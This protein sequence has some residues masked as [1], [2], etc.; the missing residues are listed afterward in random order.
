[1]T[2][3][4][5]WHT[6]S[7]E[8]ALMRL[9][10]SRQ[11]LSADEAKSRLLRDGPN[12]LREEERV[13]PWRILR[14]QFTSII[15]W[16]LI[17]AA[18]ISGAVGEWTDCIAILAIVVVNGVIGFSQ[19]YHAE[20]AIAALRRMAA[21]HARVMRDGAVRD[22]AASEVVVGDVIRLEA[23]D[24]VPADARLLA[25]ASLAC[26][27]AAL[28]GEA[29][30]VDKRVDAIAAP[31]APLGDRAD[32][33]FMGTIVSAGTGEAVVV[34]IGMD[35]ELGRIAGLI[36]DAAS[37]DA[38]PLQQRLAAFGRML[39][40]AAL[41]IVVLLFGLGLLRGEPLLPLIMT[42]ISLAVA[43]VPEGLPAVVT[44]AL[45]LGVKRMARRR[46]LIRRL[47]AVETLGSTNVICTD[48]TGTLTMNQMTVRAVVTGGREYAIAG[49]GYE[50][51]G[52]ITPPAD[53]AAVDLARL[54]AI[55]AGCNGAWL[56]QEN[57]AWTTVGDP[58]D[59]ALLVFA[60]KAGVQRETIERD[61]PVV[62]ELPFDSDRKLMTNVRKTAG[63]SAQAVAMVKGAP[64]LL[65]HRCTHV[66]KD[67]VSVPL[68]DAGRA[69][70]TEAN[71]RLASS[72]LRV[73]GAAERVV[74]SAQAAGQAANIE[75]GLTFVGLYGMYDPPRAEAKAAVAQC[76]AAGIRVVMITGDHPRTA[77]AVAHELGI[78]S[79]HD[80]TL[81][82]Q[83]LDAM[84][85][86]ALRAAA[87]AVAVYARVTAAHKLRIVRAWK[88]NQ[89]VVAMTG[90]GVNDA[91]AIKGADI[92]IA[93]GR[94]GTEVTKQAADMIVTDD[95]FV[96][97]VAAVEEGRGI[98]ANIRKTI[99]YLLAGNCG[100]ILLMAICVV[101]G[102]PM[103]LL[104][105]HLL[106]INLVSDGLPAL[107]LAS[108]PIDRDVMRQPPRPRAAAI[109]DRSFLVHMAITGILTA[110]VSLAVFM[111]TLRHAD[112]ST[113]R[114]HAFATLVFCELLRAFGARSETRLFWLTGLAGNLKLALIVGISIAIQ[115]SSHHLPWIGNLLQTQQLGWKECLTLLALGCI[116]LAVLELLKL[117][118]RAPGPIAAMKA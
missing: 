53:A 99:Q 58:T 57:G 19:E 14:A 32:V 6:L 17:A 81:S 43:A 68:D 90:D 102:L 114:T 113:A 103:P 100:E 29:E 87:P 4:P 59:A 50:P 109:A 88:A 92:G 71:V 118:R 18:V 46:A 31:T 49:E 108:D 47:P 39:V 93:M 96:S 40:W 84:D 67:G 21:P 64:D 10:S 80:R 33:V 16:V 83:E 56:R 13:R 76:H 98:Y 27:E 23:G 115:I 28:T 101:I 44:V 35:T 82:G 15:I 55:A 75:Q 111:Y 52:A 54:A 7:A 20:R 86:V 78:A 60:A 36:K 106:W 116:P 107:S 95:N 24:L 9:T 73:L 94:S 48:K 42:A 79:E 117:L 45:A 85:E 51:V 5:I 63:G 22:I 12:E 77:L 26:T 1:M 72:A 41:A 25:V 61:Q 97:I 91:P 74:E 2:D 8:D 3:Q 105:I 11:G 38:T 89:A 104:P 34:A 110:G 30:A 112:L 62:H 66:L 70:I 69:A 37:D 65:L